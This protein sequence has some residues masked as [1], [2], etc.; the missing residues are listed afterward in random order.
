M[1][2]C[3]CYVSSSLLLLWR[4][5]W[6]GCD[7]KHACSI[8]LDDGLLFTTAT[9]KLIR[10][11][12]CC[13]RRCRCFLLLNVNWISFRGIFLHAN[14]LKLPLCEQRFQLSLDWLSFKFVRLYPLK[15]LILSYVGLRATTLI[16]YHSIWF[17]NAFEWKREKRSSC[18]C[19]LLL[20]LLL[21][22]SISI[23][24]IEMKSENI[25]SQSDFFF[26]HKNI[27]IFLLFDLI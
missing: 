20:L 26:I 9:W 7:C 19:L 10:T 4:F 2:K 17:E 23:E 21:L 16:K 14:A 13:R 12:F 6:N 27:Y 18:C 1:I 24:A 22:V 8:K 3:R 25:E 15:C 11:F 5:K